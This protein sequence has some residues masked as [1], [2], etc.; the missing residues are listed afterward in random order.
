MRSKVI[1]D[2]LTGKLKRYELWKLIVSLAVCALLVTLLTGFTVQT[3]SETNRNNNYERAYQQLE[4]AGFWFN[5]DVPLAQQVTTGESGG[6][7]LQL[8]WEDA[9]NN[10]Y[11]V[12][13][14]I[15]D[16]KMQRI[17][18]ENDNPPRQIL[19]AES[20]NSS[21]EL[22]NCILTN[23][24]V[25]LKLTALVGTSSCAKTYQIRKRPEP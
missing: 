17:Y 24:I 20:I 12:T 9:S 6:F 15:T 8:Y 1:L 7:P 4:N 5:H 11:R 21:P 25:S 23:G 2:K 19:V 16:D 14:T 13:F 18:I 10:T 3:I 22:T